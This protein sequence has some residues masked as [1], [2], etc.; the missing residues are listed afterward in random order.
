[1]LSRRKLISTTPGFAAG[2]LAGS[3]L[4]TPNA[5]GRAQQNGHDAYFSTLNSLLKREGPGHP[6]MLLDAARTNHN[7]DQITKSVGP[8]KQYRVVVK[9]LPSEPLLRHVTERAKTKALMVFHQ[10]FLNAIGENFSDADVL[11]GKPMPVQA[12]RT[13]YQKHKNKK[14]SAAN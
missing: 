5:S 11:I 8:D 14:F 9:S 2:A 7:L 13:F 3:V 12:A 1:M 6:V 10:P 4:W